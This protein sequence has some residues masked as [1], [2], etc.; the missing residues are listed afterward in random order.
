MKKAF[1]S[2]R[3]AQKQ[4][5]SFYMKSAGTEIAGTPSAVSRNWKWRVFAIL[6]LAFDE[7]PKGIAFAR[8][9]KSLRADP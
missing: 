7:R 5:R 3:T 1:I 4:P 2:Y 6:L 9:G 8:N